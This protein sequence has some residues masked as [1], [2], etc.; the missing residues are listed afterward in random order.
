LFADKEITGLIVL[1][2]TVGGFVGIKANADK[3]KQSQLGEG[4]RQVTS[5]APL[6]SPADQPAES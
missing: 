5:E 3:R 2:S 6:K 4:K 1:T